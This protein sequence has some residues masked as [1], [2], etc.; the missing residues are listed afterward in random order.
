MEINL[1]IAQ[2]FLSRSASKK[3][4]VLNKTDAA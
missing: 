2:K 1:L 4:S 3:L